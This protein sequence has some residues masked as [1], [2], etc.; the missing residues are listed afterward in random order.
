METLKIQDSEANVLISFRDEMHGNTVSSVIC[1]MI[2]EVLP[3][4][5]TGLSILDHTYQRTLFYG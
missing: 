2:L 5:T 1:V 4:L 3:N